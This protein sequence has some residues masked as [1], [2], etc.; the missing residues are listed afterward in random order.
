MCR[1]PSGIDPS[2]TLPVNTMRSRRAQARFPARDLIAA[3]GVISYAFLR[4]AKRSFE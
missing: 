2:M 4:S 3:T 1:R